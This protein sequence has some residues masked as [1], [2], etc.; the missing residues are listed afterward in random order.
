MGYDLLI[1]QGKTFSKVLRWEV[2]PVVF[3]PITSISNSA[4]ATIVA[5]S[6]GLPSGWR[7]AF[8][9]L[10]GMTNLNAESDP[11]KTKDYHKVTVTDGDTVTIDGLNTTDYKTHTA[12][13]GY[14]RFNTPVDMT[15]YTARMKIKDKVG[16]T[17]LA[18]TEA[19]DSP[20]NILTA[21]IDNSTKTITLSISATNTAA[22]TWTKGTYDIEMVSNGGVVTELLAGNV[23]VSKEVTT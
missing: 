3:K 7:V 15:G 5:T 1:K 14:L 2:P 13:T 4:P 22:L 19:G 9:S 18:S 20:K 17:V 16:G 23:T 21:A 8:V 10:K 6:H 11:P 12:S